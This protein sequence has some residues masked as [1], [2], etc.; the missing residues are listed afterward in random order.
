MAGRDTAIVSWIRGNQ[1]IPYRS[2]RLTDDIKVLIQEF[3]L[4]PMAVA[5]AMAGKL[6]ACLYCGQRL[7][8]PVSKRVGYGPVCAK[9]WGLPHK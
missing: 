7:S 4:D 1:L 6:G 3:A 8:D 2:D 9:N 5:K